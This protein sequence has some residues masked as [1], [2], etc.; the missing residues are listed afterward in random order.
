[1]ITCEQIR[2]NPEINTYIQKAD[3]SL[4]VIGYT[5]HSFAH[6]SYVAAQA[7]NIMTILGYPEREAE[8]AWIAG[9]MHDIGNVVNRYNHAL[10]GAVMCFRLLDK[11]GMPADEVAAITSAV[12]NHDEG[13]AFPVSPVAAALILAD[14]CD[15]RRTRVRNTDIASFDIHDRVNYAVERSVLSVPDAKTVRLE[16]SIDTSISPVLNYFEIFM[17]RMLLCTK[18]A[19]MLST[20]FE[21]I[22]NGQKIL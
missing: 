21:L 4:N 10:S 16:L 1:M 17:D 13:T 3:E 7:K 12:G 8:L 9:Y 15:V 6:V 11:M 14:K 5:E 18:A 19:D 2:N 22:I 20:K